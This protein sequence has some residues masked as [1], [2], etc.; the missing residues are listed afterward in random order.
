V[1]GVLV[2]LLSMAAGFEATLRGTGN[3]GRVLLLRG[4]ST[5]ELGSVITRDQAQVIKDAPGIARG[6]DGRPLALSEV[7]LLT[8][9]SKPGSPFPNNMVVRGTHADVSRLRP[10]FKIVA[11]R[12]FE[13]GLREV[14]VGKSAAAQFETLKLGGTVDVRDGPW[15]IVGLFETGGNVHE[16]ELWV[17]S[18]VLMTVSRRQAFNS[19]MLQLDDPQGFEPLKKVLSEDPRLKVSIQRE[20]DYYASRSRA[21]HK[22]INILGY[23]VA[24]IMGIGA[25]F[26]ALNVM[27][28]AVATRT[29]EI[30][31]LRA[32]GFGS[33]PVVVSVL[34]E[35]LILAFAGGL[36]GAAGAYLFFNGFTVNTLNFQTFSQV[37]FDFAVTPQL[38]QQGLVWALAMGLIGG[39]FPAVRAARLPVVDALRAS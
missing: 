14:I 38:M 6:A 35:S 3:E 15:Q 16:S 22:M 18:E 20:P 37:A 7:Y 31:T 24:I 9:V 23:T 11:G 36:L 27:Y 30:A 21:L 28:A 33:L 26:G 8:D 17:D 4:G 39:L 2:A 29:V 12:M 1:V 10:E 13:P 32:I 5:A 25:V 34:I 19:V